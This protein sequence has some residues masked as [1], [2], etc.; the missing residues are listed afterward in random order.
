[1]LGGDCQYHRVKRDHSRSFRCRLCPGPTGRPC[2]LRLVRNP[3]RPAASAVVFG[4]L[5]PR[6]R[7][8]PLVADRAGRSP[9]ARPLSVRRLWWIPAR[10]GTSRHRHGRPIFGRAEGIGDL[11]SDASGIAIGGGS[12]RAVPRQARGGQL[13]PSP[14]QPA[15]ALPTL[16]SRGDIGT[17]P[18]GLTGRPTLEACRAGQTSQPGMRGGY[19]DSSSGSEPSGPAGTPGSG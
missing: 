7:T 2:R 8:Q 14:G 17:S 10:S 13:F 5:R 18:G 16:P 4:S 3:T 19:I 11:A 1:M 6:A 9:A 15:N 12:R